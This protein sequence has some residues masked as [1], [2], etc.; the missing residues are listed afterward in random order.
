MALCR[1]T[2]ENDMGQTDSCYKWNTI[3]IVL[4]NVVLLNVVAPFET[5]TN[6]FEMLKS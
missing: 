3:F 5:V 1:R 2:L 6:N 4:L